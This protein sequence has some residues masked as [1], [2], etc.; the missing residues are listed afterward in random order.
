MFLKCFQ[1]DQYIRYS[2]NIEIT[3]TMNAYTFVQVVPIT[4]A[5]LTATLANIKN[6]IAL[7][8]S[9][10]LRTIPTADNNNVKFNR[11]IQQVQFFHPP[12]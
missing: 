5:P 9:L 7:H 4:I 2:L 3:N 11:T 10:A 1:I 8:A 6:T 12:T